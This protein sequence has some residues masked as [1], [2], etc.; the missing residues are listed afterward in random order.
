[1]KLIAVLLAAVILGA[2]AWLYVPD[3]PRAALEARYAASP[4]SFREVAGLRLHLRDTGPRDAPAVILLHG[5]ASS[6]HTWEDWARVLDRDHRV[7]R[8]DLPG[9]GLTGAD[10]TG[11]YTDERSAAVLLALMDGL[12]LR[13]TSLV[14]SSMGG[15]IAWDFA[16]RHPDRVDRL[17]LM[18][19]DGFA[20]PG[21]EYGVAPKVPMLVRLLPYVLPTPLLRKSLSAAYADPAAM[22]EERL[23]RYR[24]MLLAP[25]VRRAIVART[26][27]GALADPVPLLR[28]ITAPTLL[29]WGEKDAM[30]PVANAADYQRALPDSRLV[31]FPGLGHV[32][33]E[34]A[35]DLSLEPVRAFLGG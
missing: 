20:G 12:G 27:Q 6:L 2:A 11:D 25:G 31:V 13:R 14:G 28:R 22:T 29:V 30:I 9:F 15:R 18:A 5:F 3:K 19:P 23:A 10:P 26:G 34:E 16:A 24:D 4:D 1:M 32:P 8:L 7:I 33:Q 21:R 35:P 17:V